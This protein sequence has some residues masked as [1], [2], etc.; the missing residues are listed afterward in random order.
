[1]C[2]Y[3]LFTFL[4][5]PS[6]WCKG[7]CVCACVHY[8]HLYS[9]LSVLHLFLSLR[10]YSVYIT[11][12]PFLYILQCLSFFFPLLYI[13]HYHMILRSVDW[14]NFYMSIFLPSFL[15]LPVQGH[16]VGSSVQPGLHLA[17]TYRTCLFSVSYWNML[18][19]KLCRSGG[20]YLCVDNW[21]KHQ[22]PYFQKSKEDA[23]ESQLK[24]WTFFKNQTF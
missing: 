17:E 4:S 12:H 11:I 1:M 7:F 9:L 18:D 21:I 13:V 5:I 16:R 19:L 20:S 22:M 3:Y 6:Y 8:T 10:V 24:Y 2:I 14:L 23:D 15:A